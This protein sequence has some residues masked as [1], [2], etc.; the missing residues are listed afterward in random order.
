M[1]PPGMLPSSILLPLEPSASNS[2]SVSTTSTSK[3]IS[4]W[5]DAAPWGTTSAEVK[6]EVSW[7]LWS[8]EDCEEIG[9]LLSGG[10]EVEC[11]EL[12]CIEVAI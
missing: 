9:E 6:V 2:E 7:G 10:V 8:I 1:A 5:W 12:D 4:L 3:S 11:M